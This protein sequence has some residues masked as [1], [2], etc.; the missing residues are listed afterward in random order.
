MT[1]DERRE[2]LVAF[3]EWLDRVEGYQG[4]QDLV[5]EYLATRQ[6][7]GE[8]VQAV[9]IG[10][11]AEEIDPLCTWCGH[12]KSQHAASRDQCGA[13]DCECVAW[14]DDTPPAQQRFW[15]VIGG[16]GG[17]FFVPCDAAGERLPGV[18][19]LFEPD[20]FPVHRRATEAEARS[21]G[22]ASGLPKWHP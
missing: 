14:P 3:A 19:L 18:F 6:P 7:Q 8:L 21:D 17:W 20:S 16:F 11:T 10:H 15:R 13:P 4:M 22:E 5:E 12:P 1:T 9:P 2:L